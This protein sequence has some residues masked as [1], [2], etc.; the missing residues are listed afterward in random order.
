MDKMT[1]EKYLTIIFSSH[2]SNIGIVILRLNQMSIHR[3]VTEKH[4]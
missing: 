2:I 3:E 4:G 1:E